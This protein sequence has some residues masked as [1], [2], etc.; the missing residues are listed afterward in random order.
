MSHPVLALARLAALALA[1]A[2]ASLAQAHTTATRPH[3]AQAPALAALG[4]APGQVPHG[5]CRWICVPGYDCS[6]TCFPE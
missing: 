2:A 4:G 3:A 5:R 6:Y 1:G